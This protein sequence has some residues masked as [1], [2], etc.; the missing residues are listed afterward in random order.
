MSSTALTVES[1]R[2]AVGEW[3]ANETAGQDALYAAAGTLLRNKIKEV[4]ALE[5]AA[6]SDVASINVEEVLYHTT[7][8]GLL[9]SG[10]RRLMM[11]VTAELRS[12]GFVITRSP[13]PA[14]EF[15]LCL[16]GIKD[17]MRSLAQ[18][19]ILH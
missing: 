6:D 2:E 1:L 12:I 18:L 14:E 9:M 3:K 7:T 19:A 4:V 17:V 8:A 15:H 10:M 16:Y 11:E 5:Y 13:N